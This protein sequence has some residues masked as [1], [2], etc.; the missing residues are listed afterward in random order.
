MFI[1]YYGLFKSHISHS[2]KFN[3][4]DIQYGIWYRS[5]ACNKEYH[6]ILFMPSVSISIHRLYCWVMSERV[7]KVYRTRYDIQHSNLPEIKYFKSYKY[8]HKA[9]QA[10]FFIVCVYLFFLSI[11][12]YHLVG[13]SFLFDNLISITSLQKLHKLTFHFLSVVF[14]CARCL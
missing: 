4:N 3:R 14:C 12:S 8:K 5:T 13:F 9:S 2:R 10:L 7:R 1:L 6:T 11:L